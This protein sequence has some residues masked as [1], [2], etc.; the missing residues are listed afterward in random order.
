MKK[1][2]SRKDEEEEE[3]KRKEVQK[4][5]LKSLVTDHSV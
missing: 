5:C 3:R 2:K 4:S 1:K